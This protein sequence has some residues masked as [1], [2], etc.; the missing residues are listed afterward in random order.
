MKLNAE[1]IQKIKT[2]I[3]GAKVSCGYRSPYNGAR[4]VTNTGSIKNFS[5]K[6]YPNGKARWTIT[7]DFGDVPFFDWCNSVTN[8]ARYQVFGKKVK[9]LAEAYFTAVKDDKAE[10]FHNHL[11]TMDDKEFK[12]E[13]V[14][15]A[16]SEVEW[17]QKHITRIKARFPKKFER[18]FKRNFPD[19][20][21]SL[22]DR[23]WNYSFTMYFD[24]MEDVPA[25]LLNKK[26]SLGNGID[27]DKKLMSNTSY[28]WKLVK[29]NPQ[30]NFSK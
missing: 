30:F 20:E 9:K 1:E 28:I 4:I 21:Y 7:T 16:K 17:L 3:I 15:V 25:S 11:S 8:G 12:I 5:L 26:N 29:N 19:A 13:D 23:C 22:E 27:F 2:A 24:S 14:E 18:D 6:T 10:I